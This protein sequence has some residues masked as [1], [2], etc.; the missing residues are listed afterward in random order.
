MEQAGGEKYKHPTP[1]LSTDKAYE[2][3]D[4]EKWLERIS[5]AAQSVGVQ[6][7]TIRCTAKLDGV[8][9]RYNTKP[10]LATRG[11]G[12]VGRVITSLLQN[13]LVIKGD[14]S[15]DGIGEIVMPQEYFDKHLSHMT[16]P[17][18]VVAGIVNAN[19]LS[20]ESRKILRE[21]GVHLVLYK[22]MLSVELPLSEFASS[23]E[24]IENRLRTE[25]HYPFDGVVYEVVKDSIK[26]LLGSNSH[27]NLWQIA[28]KQRA[29]GVIATVKG[30]T[31]PIGRTSVLTPLI[32]IDPVTIDGSEVTKMTGHYVGN[33]KEKGIG[34]GSRVSVIK[35]GE[36]IPAIQSVIIGSTDHNLPSCC[37]HCGA[38]L[39]KR[40]IT[41]NEI[42]NDKSKKVIKKEANWFCTNDECKGKARA[43]IMY[44][45]EL[46]K[47]QLFGKATVNK[48]IEGGF[49]S[50]ESVYKMTRNDYL[51]CG[52][53]EGQTDNLISE[54]N[55]VKSSPINDYQLVASLGI[56]GLGRGTG[57]KLFAHYNIKDISTLSVDQLSS[58]RGFGKVNS[59]SIT[60]ALSKSA[61]LPFLLEAYEKVIIHTKAQAEIS[62]SLK[63]SSPL[64][65]KKVVFTG[66]CS[67]PRSEMSNIAIE[68]GCEVQK[69]VVKG[70]DYLVC[71]EKV[72]AK[73]IEAAQKKGATVISEFHEISSQRLDVEIEEIKNVKTSNP[74]TN[75]NPPTEVLTSDIGSNGQMTLF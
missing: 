55:R 58:I 43:F 68:L 66:T 24:Q 67:R 73:K 14:D 12:E 33:L 16:H 50:V 6:S 48:L 74:S 51:S 41:L 44:H 8:A 25:T 39:D 75:I 28:K 45:F 47:A 35:A 31:Y 70:T 5:K 61:L 40:D 1:M 26:E 11:D 56:S 54:I 15:V 20:E 60:N 42:V 17:R 62:A 3:A 32:H 22:D 59:D 72:G 69:S 46:V 37:P 18:S 30:I 19:K 36:I 64:A 65:G 34:I 71:G 9:C 7:P 38:E 53:G 4:I 10:L 57:K 23:H 52:L 49:N 27:H 29:E 21:G 2:V 13:G 63:H